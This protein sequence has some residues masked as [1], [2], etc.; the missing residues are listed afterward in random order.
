[1]FNYLVGIY[2]FILANLFYLESIL[3][4]TGLLIHLFAQALEQR[5]CR[6]PAFCADFRHPSAT[7]NPPTAFNFT[8]LY[9]FIPIAPT[10][11]L[12]LLSQQEKKQGFL[13]IHL[14]TM[15]DIV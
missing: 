2:I 14:D 7:T 11:D 5:A 12:L 15:I 1:M 6:I 8:K 4:I 9:M 10:L 3:Q 13:L